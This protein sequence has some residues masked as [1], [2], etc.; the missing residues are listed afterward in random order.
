MIIDQVFSYW[1]RRDMVYELKFIINII[2]VKIHF[3]FI[4]NVHLNT[5]VMVNSR[6]NC[7][8]SLQIVHEALMRWSEVDSCRLQNW[9][10][11]Q[12]AWANPSPFFLC[13]CGI[14]RF[15]VNFI[16]HLV[17]L[18]KHLHILWKNSIFWHSPVKIQYY[19]ILIWCMYTYLC[20]KQ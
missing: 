14:F 5:F 15:F 10:M 4:S 8:N 1:W 7:L 17:C 12:R 2:I 19:N 16:E 20:T 6:I 3:V 11:P 9:P 13:F 18:D